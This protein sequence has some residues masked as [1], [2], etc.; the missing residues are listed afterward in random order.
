M[1][2]L[3]PWINQNE[4]TNK[5]E[6]HLLSIRDDHQKMIHPNS[7]PTYNERHQKIIELIDWTLEKYRTANIKE[8]N[9][10][11]EEAIIIDNIIEELDKKRDIAINKKKKAMLKDEVSIYRLEENTLD[12]ILFI[13]RDFD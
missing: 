5:F 4:A 10:Q 9:Q 8:N 7:H 11:N 12:Y 3:D 2:N 6:S 1:R 13:M